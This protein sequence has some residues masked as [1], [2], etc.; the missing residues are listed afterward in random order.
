MA[1][2]LRVEY[3]HAFYHVI[4]RGHRKENIF[5][6]DE[7]RKKFLEKLNQTAQRYQLK[8]HAFVMMSN[9]YHL[10][11]ETPGANLAKAMHDFNASYANW[12]RVKYRLV[13]SIFQGRYKSIIVEKDEYLLVLS[14]YIHLNPCRAG[15]VKR[16]EEYKWSSYRSYVGSAKPESFLFTDEVLAQ[17]RC[18]K[19]YQAYV[20]EI[21]KREGEIKKEEVYG[22]NSILGSDG[23]IRRILKGEKR[24]GDKEREVEELKDLR[25]VSAEDIME[26]IITSFRIGEGAI[27]DRRKGNPYRKL[28]VFMLRKHTGMSL[29]EIGGVLGMDYGAVSEMSRYFARELKLKEESRKMAELVDQKVKMRALA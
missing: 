5:K 9:H 7:D 6:T 15:M 22:V 29:K 8:V 3:E 1:R 21:V 24:S 16:P 23:F 27:L 18:K 10:L 13:G 2:P 28:Y 19:D 11:V 14:A 26:I 20:N 12:F 4:S 25:R 17:F